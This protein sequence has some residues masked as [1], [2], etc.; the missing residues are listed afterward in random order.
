MTTPLFSFPMANG[1]DVKFPRLGVTLACVDPLNCDSSHPFRSGTKSGQGF[2]SLYGSSDTPYQ[3]Q[4]HN[5][6][7]CRNPR[8]VSFENLE[9]YWAQDFL[10]TFTDCLKH[11]DLH[12]AGGDLMHVSKIQTFEGSSRTTIL[13]ESDYTQ[14]YSYQCCFYPSF[15]QVNVR[16]LNQSTPYFNPLFSSC[17]DFNCS[18][19]QNCM[20]HGAVDSRF[21]KASPHSVLWYLLHSLAK[22]SDEENTVTFWDGH[23][24]G[25]THTSATLAVQLGYDLG[26]PEVAT[27]SSLVGTHDM[28]ARLISR[29][30]TGA[31]R[32]SDD[33]ETIDSNNNL[34][35]LFCPFV[36]SDNS[37]WKNYIG[38]NFS[39]LTLT[40]YDPQGQDRSWP[41]EEFRSQGWNPLTWDSNGADGQPVENLDFRLKTK[42]E[43]CTRPNPTSNNL[44][45]YTFSSNS[46]NRFSSTILN[47]WCESFLCPTSPVC[48]SLLNSF[49][50]NPLSLTSKYCQ[51]W[52]SWA[53]NSYQ[54]SPIFNL[55]TT[56]VDPAT[57][58]RP[59]NA[60][61]YGAYSA[62]V[63]TANAS[64][65]RAC[66]ITRN[67]VRTKQYEDMCTPL[68]T[69]TYQ[70]NFPRLRVFHYGDFVTYTTES[71]F[72]FNVDPPSLAVTLT[73]N[74]AAYSY[75][76]NQA[77]CNN[78]M[79][80]ANEAVIPTDK[81]MCMPV[82]LSTQLA[83]LTLSQTPISSLVYSD[84]VAQIR[85]RF[86]ASLISVNGRFAFPPPP[87]ANY[88]Q[89]FT[90]G[91]AL[92]QSTIT[93]AYPNHATDIVFWDPLANSF[94][95][96]HTVIVDSS[97]TRLDVKRQENINH[98]YS[99]SSIQIANIYGLSS[100]TNNGLLLQNCSFDEFGLIGIRTISQ[101]G[102]IPCTEL[103]SYFGWTARLPQGV[104][105]S[106]F[107]SFLTSPINIRVNNL[108]EPP[109]VPLNL[110]YFP[111]LNINF[112]PSVANLLGLT[113]TP[114][115]TIN[116]ISSNGGAFMQAGSYSFGYATP[117]TGNAPV[118][119]YK[120][121]TKAIF[122]I[123]NTST[124][125]FTNLSIL[126][127]DIVNYSVTLG[128]TSLQPQQS[129]Q[130]TVSI[131]KVLTDPNV[132]TT[133]VLLY[134]SVSWQGSLTS[135]DYPVLGGFQIVQGHVGRLL[136]ADTPITPY[137]NNVFSTFV[138]DDVLGPNGVSYLS[139]QN[140][141]GVGYTPPKLPSGFRIVPL[142]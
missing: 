58:I 101:C 24:V 91:G 117:F 107:T 73:L 126:N 116:P 40:N 67:M 12:T 114:T 27:L 140:V 7:D 23:Q 38:Q 77:A 66:S 51:A 119:T 17:H 10:Q 5:P 52:H 132:I 102:L 137:M 28:A 83:V 85:E 103:P 21:P 125:A 61:P 84:F 80:G 89:S 32:L 39:F 127:Y 74:Y 135:L 19:K 86:N 96:S 64:L 44:N 34:Y 33:Q 120:A 53:A 115:V 16:G 15:Y 22:V 106:D 31:C 43:C 109:P 60:M 36:S 4:F 99:I 26:D 113:S 97:A 110:E 42:L 123:V 121:T 75:T 134:D 29:E 111:T 69:S 37:V 92:S 104:A 136:S 133:P 128:T 55:P 68:F 130:I 1:R 30:S 71:V 100:R 129:T 82:G 108:L 13:E 25:K 131:N 49:C 142:I 72:P 94:G 65:L 118:Q 14:E 2:P 93:P 122:N 81:Y 87:T 46:S 79:R 138:E 18:E 6:G 105:T 78:L 48:H 35:R 88:I 11:S 3:F 54:S 62:G 59:Y 41:I 45:L 47:G 90:I 112:S 139:N 20:G 50:S 8:T 95:I 98:L 63:D 124:I 76:D 56:T 70:T 57:P 9:D 141:Y